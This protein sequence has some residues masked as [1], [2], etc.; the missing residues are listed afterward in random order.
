MS[1]TSNATSEPWPDD[2]GLFA[3][4]ISA[5][6][7]ATQAMAM[8]YGRPSETSE[9]SSDTAA[10]VQGT[11]NSNA[12]SN[13]LSAMLEE[14]SCLI[15]DG[16]MGTN[17]MIA[18]LGAGRP[19][20]FWNT[21]NPDPVA[22]L[23]RAFVEAGSDIVL[24]N[25]FGANSLRLKLND[26]QSRCQNLNLEGVR[27]ARAAAD[28]VA[29]PVAVAG[30]MGPTGELMKPLGVMTAD[31]AYAAY[32]EQAEALA[33]GGVDIIWIETIFAFDELGAAVRAAA[34][35]GIPVVATMTFD[36]GGHTMMGDTPEAAMAFVQGLP[37][38]PMAFGANCGAGPSML[39]DSV[40]RLK[41]AAEPDMIIIAKGNCGVPEL[42]KDG[43]IFTGTAEVMK[44]Y[45]RMARDSGARI[46]G[47]C[48][49]RR[50]KF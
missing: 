38:P 15:A 3:S 19:P 10:P 23:Q 37:D 46:V 11:K 9:V 49:G 36:T 48:C 40:A 24:T 47:G 14:K 13:L 35:T 50:P 30:C 25:T 42:T 45:A 20:D 44:T 1:G 2:K 17:M 26:A 8:H 41:R 34:A 6:Q 29:R 4:R 5:T 22:A 12:P 21:E 28:S 27:L 18:G 33:E 31:E 32:A 39:I 43:V 16:A 7:L